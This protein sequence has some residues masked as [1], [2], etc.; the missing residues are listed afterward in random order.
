MAGAPGEAE[1]APRD[2]VARAI[3]RQILG[4]D[5]AFLDA[6]G[7]VGAAFPEAFPTVFAACMAAGV[8]PR[9]QP[10]PVAPAAHYHMGGVAADADGRTTLEGLYAAGECAGTG[11]HGANRLASN[12]LVEAVVFGRRA[13]AAAAQ[14]QG[15]REGRAEA[16]PAL[17]REDLQRLRRAMSREAGV[18]RDRSG[19]TRLLAEIRELESAH[20]EAAPLAAA[21][22]IATAALAREE[23]RGAH[24]RAD[25]PDRAPDPRRSLI[26]WAEARHAEATPA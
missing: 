20:G 6:R 8:D 2:V 13:G 3:H 11:V 16:A 12:S 23:S 25:F 22:L 21:R 10:I 4:G 18:V 9:V 19:L 1:L 14:A 24:C 15:L 5:G 17:P 26:T 7:A